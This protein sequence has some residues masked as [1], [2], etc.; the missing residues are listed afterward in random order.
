MCEIKLYVYFHDIEIK[1]FNVAVDIE[2]KHLFL[3]A[4]CADIIKYLEQI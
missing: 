3:K 2:A 4:S 1:E